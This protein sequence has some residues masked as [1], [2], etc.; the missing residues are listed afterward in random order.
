MSDEM[1]EFDPTPEDAEGPTVEQ[2]QVSRLALVVGI[3]VMLL[4]AA[5]P[6]Y[7]ALGTEGSTA[8]ILF[9]TAVVIGLFNTLLVFGVWTWINNSSQQSPST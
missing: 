3:L 2:K 8:A 6:L 7:F 9:A 4:P 5:V 1:P